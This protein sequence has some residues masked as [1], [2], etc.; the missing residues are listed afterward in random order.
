MIDEPRSVSLWQEGPSF[1]ESDVEVV[2][3]SPQIE[4]ILDGGSLMC[5]QLRLLRARLQ[6]LRSERPLHCIGMVSATRGEGKSTISIGLA[7][8][9]ALEADRRVLLL[10]SDLRRP[11]LD[12]YL[13]LG[14]CP[15]L[16]QYLDG[17]D[18]VV[19]VRRVLPG[20]F[21]LLSAGGDAAAARPEVLGTRRMAAL[22]AGARRVF[23]HIVVDC[24]PLLPV[25]DSVTLQDHVDG[26]VFV[27]RSRHAP[28]DAVLRAMSLLKPERLKGLVFNAH[29]A[30]LPTSDDFAARRYGYSGS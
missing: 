2:A 24:P 19:S 20:N 11:A 17:E 18:D 4:A 16:V 23:D 14:P 6:S 27:V 7:R 29:E 8:T 22:I 15:G 3:R 9:L 10:E 26:F 1:E 28:R 5:E 12:S 25:A 30:I 21:Y 13:G